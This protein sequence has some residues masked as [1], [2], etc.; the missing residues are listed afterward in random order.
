MRL[1]QWRTDRKLTIAGM[2]RALGIQ[3][4]NPGGTLARIEAGSR[5]PDAEMVERI[6]FLTGGAVTPADMHAVRLD[7][8]KANR[9]EK[10]DGSSQDDGSSR[11]VPP[12]GADLSSA[13]AFSSQPRATTASVATGS[14]ARAGEACVPTRSEPAAPD[15]CLDVLTADGG[16]TISEAAE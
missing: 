2:A 13:P 4:V 5:Q 11:V 7:W 8:L 14:P 6:G 1:K 10:F 15:V 3:G 12:A 9:P 16:G